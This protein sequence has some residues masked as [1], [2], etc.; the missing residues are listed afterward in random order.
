MKE[1]RPRITIPMHYRTPKVTI[2]RILDVEA[3]TS[4][5]PPAMVE[6]PGVTEIELTRETLPREP[7]IVV[8]DYAG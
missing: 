6:R 7:K 5:F 4:L 1:I 8:L 2:T 3:F